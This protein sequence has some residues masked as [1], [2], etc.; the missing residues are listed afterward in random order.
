MNDTLSRLRPGGYVIDA[1]AP[2]GSTCLIDNGPAAGCSIGPSFLHGTITAH[3][4]AP[5]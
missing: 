3:L 1:A 4:G 5:A 2:G